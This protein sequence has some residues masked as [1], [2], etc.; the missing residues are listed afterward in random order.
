MA[1][2]YYLIDNPLTPDPT[3]FRAQLQTKGKKRRADIVKRIMSKNSG[4]AESELIA[5]FDEE[6]RAIEEFLE[7][8]YSID[9]GLV[10]IKPGVK[11]VFNS[12]D[13]IFTSGKHELKMNVSPLKALKEVLNRISLVKIDGTLN[14]PRI[15]IFEDLVS[16]TKNNSITPGKLAKIYGSKMKFDAADADQGIFFVKEDETEIRV[17]EYAEVG[18]KKVIFNIPQGL[19]KG[20][21]TLQVYG[22][23]SAGDLREGTLKAVLKVA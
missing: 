10:L 6:K 9:T 3:D 22:K 15:T 1:I 16:K 14:V 18:N 7:E 17:E 8:G 21:Y 20:N 2:P 13:E 12:A 11:G 4:L 23:T 19:T 5:V